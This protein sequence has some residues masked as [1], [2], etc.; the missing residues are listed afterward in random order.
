[1]KN[2][3]SEQKQ[4]GFTLIELL[5]VIAIIGILAAMLLPALSKVK[6]KAQI[7]R[8]KSEMEMLKTA[9]Q[10][11]YTTYNRYPVSTNAMNLAGGVN[12][13]TYGDG[14]FNEPGITT[15]LLNDEVVA[16]LMD[17]EKYPNGT[18]TINNGH[19]KNVQRIQFLNAK[20]SEAVTSPGVGPDGVYRDPWGNP[21][22]L[23]I[24]LNFDQNVWMEFIVSKRYREALAR[25]VGMD[26][27][28]EK[29][30]PGTA[31]I[32]PTMGQ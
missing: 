18:A 8:A 28:M 19:L 7:N 6:E 31:T 9:V 27:Q 5:V 25:S 14:T 11:Y 4:A 24:D 30:L 17:M 1:M 3:Y 16:V 29:T 12:D 20:L 26:S 32:M 13:F 21:Y 10:G 22:I 23:S 2:I 15:F